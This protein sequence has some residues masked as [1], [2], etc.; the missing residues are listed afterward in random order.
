M[1]RSS[2]KLAEKLARTRSSAIEI[3]IESGAGSLLGP[4]VGRRDIEATRRGLA[5]IRQ[6]AATRRENVKKA[7]TSAASVKKA[8]TSAASP[9][10]SWGKI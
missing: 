10:V 3:V 8:G 4:S 9:T 7:G 2:R 1:G 5:A 6:T